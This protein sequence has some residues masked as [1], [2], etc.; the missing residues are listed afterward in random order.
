MAQGSGTI[1]DT[2]LVVVVEGDGE[3]ANGTKYSDVI[4]QNQGKDELFWTHAK[5]TVKGATANTRLVIVMYRVLE[6][7]ET[8]AY[9][10]NCKYNVSGAVR[11]S[12][13]NI[14]ISK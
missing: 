3:F 1:D 5:T 8:A 10:G 9:T 12:L 11:F 14:K 7:Y 6:G 13:D 4:A 2:K